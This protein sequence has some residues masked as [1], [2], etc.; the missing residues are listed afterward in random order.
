MAPL[1]IAGSHRPDEQQRAASGKL[2]MMAAAPSRRVLIVDDD[3]D[4]SA[5]MEA[6]LSEEGYDVRVAYEEKSAIATLKTFDAD[7]AFFDLRI[8]PTVDGLSIIAEAR[9]ARPDLVSIL[10]TAYPDQDSAINSVRSAV[11]DY[12]QKPAAPEE[13]LR[14]AREA[15]AEADS[16]REER[17]RLDAMARKIELEASQAAL[18]RTFIAGIGQEFREPLSLIIGYAELLANP[19]WLARQPVGNIGAI[20]ADIEA[21]SAQ[22]LK[23]VSD[24]AAAARTGSGEH[25]DCSRKTTFARFAADLAREYIAVTGGTPPCLAGCGDDVAQ[26]QIEIP[27]Q[28]ASAISYYCKALH[29]TGASLSISTSSLPGHIELVIRTQGPGG[30]EQVSSDAALSSLLIA[31]RLL[32]LQPCPF[33]IE[34]TDRGEDLLKVRLPV[35][36]PRLVNLSADRASP[37]EQA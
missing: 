16:I 22:L 27:A 8:S 34:R 6:L 10:I 36:Q 11:F 31:T 33:S 4:V 26:L 13:I 32:W 29:R 3:V 2:A 18:R 5:M 19:G 7:I 9:K 23:V 35:R 1:A 25:D 17:E 15:F 28:L 20:A 37:G 12:L 21:S 14:V 24:T 30:P